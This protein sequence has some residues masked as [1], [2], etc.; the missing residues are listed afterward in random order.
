MSTDGKQPEYIVFNSQD[1]DIG[2]RL[3]TEG[4]RDGPDILNA[5]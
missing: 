2:L 1:I 3:V 4:H 5:K